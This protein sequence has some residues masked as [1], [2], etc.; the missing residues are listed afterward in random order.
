M[1]TG[2]PTLDKLL[3]SRVAHPFGQFGTTDDE[4]TDNG[5]LGCTH[6]V[7]RFIAHAY[8]GKWYSHDQISKLAGYPFSGGATNRGMRVSESQRLIAALKLPYV[9]RGGL[10][11]SQ[12][13]VASNKGPC[14]FSIRYGNWPNWQNYHG[15]ARPAP[16][17][18]PLRKAGRNQFSGFFGSHACCLLG[19]TRV[20]NGATFVRNDAY[21]MEPNHDSPARPENVP[22]DVVTQTQLNAAYR[23]VVSVLHWSNTVAFVPS[24]APTFPGGI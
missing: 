11:S 22:Y 9:Y 13:L 2:K 16:Y 20:M 15:A 24:R 7:W 8:T 21:V 18:R 19:Y 6:T 10:T 14:M 3:A 5:A 23:A 4:S 1:A 17:A 12:L